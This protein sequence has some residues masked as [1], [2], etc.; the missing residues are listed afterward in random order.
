V[1]LLSLDVRS[2][3]QSGIK[4]DSKAW[5]GVAGRTGFHGLRHGELW[6][7]PLCRELCS[8]VIPFNSRDPILEKPIMKGRTRQGSQD[9]MVMQPG[10]EAMFVC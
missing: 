7:R 5:A 8:S 4:S 2:E 10:L 3:G 6:E 9:W 1:E